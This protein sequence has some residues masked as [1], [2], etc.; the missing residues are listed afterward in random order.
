MPRYIVFHITDWAATTTRLYDR[1]IEITVVQ[2]VTAGKFLCR[3]IAHT[4]PFITAAKWYKRKQ[5]IGFIELAFH[6]M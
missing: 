6:T 1:S 2:T 5:P 3:Q 4:E